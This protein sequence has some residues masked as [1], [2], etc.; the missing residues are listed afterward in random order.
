MWFFSSRKARR[1]GPARSRLSAY[2]PRLE[3]LEDRCLLSGWAVSNGGSATLSVLP[4]ISPPDAAGDF[5]VTGYFS[6]TATFGSTTLNASSTNASY[7]AKLDP[8]CNFL[9]AEQFGGLAGTWAGIALDSSGNV[10]LTGAFDG[11][12]SF[13]S[14][15]LTSVSTNSTGYVCKMD[16]NGNFLWAQ[17]MASGTGGSWG[18][19]VAV[20]GSGNAYLTWFGSGSVGFLS[21]LDPG[22]NFLWTE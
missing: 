16:G 1:T 14:T 22:G 21:K 3:A 9:W 20:D 6:G 4:V 5:Y 10:Y 12:Q 13:G 11:T 15:T 17:R 7:V 19:D 2:R 8:N 18:R